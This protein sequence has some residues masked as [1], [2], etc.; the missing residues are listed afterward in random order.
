MKKGTKSFSGGD[1][2]KIY[3]YSLFDNFNVKKSNL[4]WKII[5][6]LAFKLEKL[7]KLYDKII[8]KEYVREGKLFDITNSKNI[9]HIGCG[10]FPISAMTLSKFNGGK[11]VGIDKN[12][13]SVERANEI[14][15]KKNLKDRISIKQAEGEIFP[16]DKFDT[17]IIS[18]CSVPKKEVLENVFKTAKKNSKIVVRE[19][20]GPNKLVNDLIKSYDD[21]EVVKRIENYNFPTSHW[22]SFYLLKK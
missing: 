20:Y 14:I 7:G 22:E 4:F 12:Y 13:K 17:I 3:S 19:L 15:N 2:K 1:S 8:S 6:F 16:V 10:S 18:A 11:I 5:D 21:I 9:L